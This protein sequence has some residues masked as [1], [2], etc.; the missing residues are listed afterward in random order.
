MAQDLRGR[1]YRVRPITAPRLLLDP[2]EANGSDVARY[3]HTSVESDL[4]AAALAGV[5]V[6]INAAGLATPDA[7]GT[8]ELYGA[9]ALLPAVVVEASRR[10]GVARVIHLSSAA[11]QGRREVLDE[12][13]VA[14]PFS[15]YSRSKALG[16]RAALFSARNGST[17]LIIVRATSVQGHN[18]PTTRSLQRVARSLLASVAA[19]GR[20]PTVVSSLGSLV[21]LVHTVG[22]NREPMPDVVLQPWEGLSTREVLRVA[23]DREPV[24]LPR[25]LCVCLLTV[26]RALG[27]VVPD[28]A[29]VVRRVELMWIGQAQI[30]GHF[31]VQAGPDPTEILRV[32][33][34]SPERQQ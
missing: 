31:A 22:T 21:E 15:P 12:T 6:V 18:R 29:G 28:L 13:L 11:V 24:V 27:F 2:A 7:A 17:D 20:Q 19:P 34:P 16:E 8:S 25:W 32:L 4:L 10:A 26:G 5:D 33:R 14:D 3:A 30:P 23:G 1:G 9:N